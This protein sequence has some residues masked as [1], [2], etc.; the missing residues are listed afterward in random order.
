MG[1]WVEEEGLGAGSTFVG[2][3]RGPLI[4]TPLFWGA[5]LARTLSPEPLGRREREREDCR[6][7]ERGREN[8]REREN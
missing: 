6:E 3:T 8:C 5:E 2:L 1:V 7:K 4:K